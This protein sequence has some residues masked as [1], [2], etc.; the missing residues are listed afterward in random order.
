MPTS[1]FAEEMR[2]NQANWDS[3][4]AVHERSVFYN[5]REYVENPTLISSTVD[6]D[7]RTI[8]D[9]NGLEVVHLQC[10]IGTDTISLARLGARV[11][12]LDFSA[13]SL[14][15]ARQLA[16]DTG[17]KAEFVFGNVL[18][19]DRLLGRQFD[20]VYTSVGVL[21]WLPDVR[22]WASSVAA[23]VRPGGRFYI[24]DS[25][26]LLAAI[27]YERDDD[28]VVLVHDYLE[29]GQGDRYEGLYTYTGDDTPLSSPVAY[30]WRHSL[31]SI[32]TA[33]IESGLRIDLVE[34]HDW[35]DWQAFPWMV[36]ESKGRWRF[37][38]GHPRLPLA[39][40]LLATKPE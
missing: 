29:D 20:L 11:V 17:A 33:L 35:V 24:R 15:V 28:S 26:P 27:D 18:E 39:F 40:S 31:G 12:G 1:K 21:C 10:H 6:W 30:E 25:H 22:R 13:E 23:C 14:R 4:A 34:E 2:A 19:A 5:L 9:V 37:P 8:G 3:R 38:T 16:A 7:R 32:I 36:E